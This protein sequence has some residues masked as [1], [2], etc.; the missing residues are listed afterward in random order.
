MKLFYRL[1]FTSL[2]IRYHFNVTDLSYIQIYTDIYIRT[3][4]LN[5]YF[6]FCWYH[7]MYRSCMITEWYMIGDSGFRI[8]LETLVKHVYCIIFLSFGTHKW[9]IEVLVQILLAILLVLFN[10]LTC[11]YSVL[12]FYDLIGISF[13][14]VDCLACFLSF[15]YRGKV[16]FFLSVR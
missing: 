1:D 14:T 11:S 8:Y 16:L 12:W 6:I 4:I 5:V 10:V 15:A 13:V 3:Y 7:Y 9:I 2:R